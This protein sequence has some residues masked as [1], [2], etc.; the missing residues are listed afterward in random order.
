MF[1][2]FLR[3][4]IKDKVFALEKADIELLGLDEE[5]PINKDEEPQKASQPSSV[6]TPEDC[7]KSLWNILC[8]SCSDILHFE[9]VRIGAIKHYPKW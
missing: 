3:K 6:M 5:E 2:N 4:K 8:D 9:M 7:M 1:K